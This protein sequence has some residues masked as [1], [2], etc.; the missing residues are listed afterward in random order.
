MER[1][2][3]EDGAHGRALRGLLGRR[4][5]EAPACCGVLVEGSRVG[6]CSMPLPADSNSASPL[7]CDLGRYPGTRVIRVG[8]EEGSKGCRKGLAGSPRR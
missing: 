2:Q 3:E 1:A 7:D 5:E 4:A 6:G 8:S